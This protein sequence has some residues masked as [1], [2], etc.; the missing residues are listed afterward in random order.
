MSTW[1][2]IVILAYLIL[3]IVNLADKFLIDNFIKSS[4]AYT[5]LVG[6]LGGVVW[7]LAPFY[8]AWPGAALFYLN[9][10][11]GALFPAALLLLYR[12]LKL[13]EASKVLVIIGGAMPIF[14]FLLAALILKERFVAHELWAVALL[15]AGTIIIAWMPPKKKFLAYILKG[16]GLKHE[17]AGQAVLTAL[18]AALIFAFF[19]VGSKVLYTA[20]PFLS[21]FIWLR[22]GSLLAVLVFLIPPSWRQE[23]FKNFKKLKGQHAKIFLANQAFAGAGFTLQ[24]YAIAIGSVTLVNA[25]QGVQYALLIILGGLLT[26]IY[27]KLIS[28]NISRAVIIQKIAAVILIAAG[29]YLLA[30]KA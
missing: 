23:I 26:M 21:A 19:F 6:L 25:L 5:F 12:S 9:L 27:P 4:R 14:S 15:I 18:G 10:I 7:L 13:G 17:M 24:N 8:L 20:Q 3:A 29:I 28:E 11:V 1:L 22:L 2:I 30:I 16:L